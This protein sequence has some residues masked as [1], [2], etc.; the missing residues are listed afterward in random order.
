MNEFPLISIILPTYNRA[1]LLPRAIQSVLDQTYP[2]WELIIWDD[3]SQDDTREVVLASDDARIKYHYDDNRGMAYAL[4]RGFEQASGEFVA[5]LDDDDQWVN[6]KLHHQYNLFH[7]FPEIDLIFG[8]FINIVAEKGT[9]NSG[10]EQNK[11]AM[12]LLSTEMVRNGVYLI[13]EHFLD[14]IA[15]ANYI[16]FDSVLIRSSVIG[17]IGGFNEALRNGMDLEYWWRA[18]LSDTNIAFTNEKLLSRTKYENSLSSLSKLTLDNHINALDSCSRYAKDYG[19]LEL[20]SSL[21]HSYCNAWQNM[22][23]ACA[24]AGDLEGMWDAFR[25]AMGYGFRPGTL[26][27]LL[28]GIFQYFGSRKN[29]QHV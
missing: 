19:R 26:R 22:I 28:A 15:H 8:D 11:G 6:H 17:K 23:T 29:G 12:Q 24:K 4:N 7:H 2:H 27:L 18:G 25:K 9:S 5:F 16:A 3:G 21:D 14:S 13:R 10:F 20:V 1:E